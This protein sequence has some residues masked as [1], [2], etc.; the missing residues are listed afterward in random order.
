MFSHPKKT[1]LLPKQID[2]NRTHF[3]SFTQPYVVGAF[4]VDGNRLYSQTK[5]NCKYVYKKVYSERRTY[6]LNTGIDSVIRKLESC[7]E[8]KLSHLLQFIMENLSQIRQPNNGSIDRNKLLMADFVCFRGL[9]RQIMCTPYEYREP[10]IILAIKFKGTIYLCAEETRKQAQDRANQT[11]ALKKILSYGFKFEQY[12][13]TGLF[14][15]TFHIHICIYTASGKFG[16]TT[17]FPHKM[18]IFS[19]NSVID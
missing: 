10:W 17:S 18:E 8:E 15:F 16:T 5:Q 14:D 19:L 2:N 3:P 9:L 11:D 4:S 1:N 6:D 12:I 13:L 7:K